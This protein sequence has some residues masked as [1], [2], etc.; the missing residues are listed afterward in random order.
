MRESSR[1]FFFCW[2]LSR[3][4]FGGKSF[5][6]IVQ[7]LRIRWKESQEGSGTSFSRKFSGQC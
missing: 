1:I 7:D 3:L 6:K 5:K 2:A 4:H